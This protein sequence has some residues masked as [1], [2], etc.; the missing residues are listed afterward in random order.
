MTTKEALK[1]LLK[2]MEDLK[3]HIS[4]DEKLYQALELVTNDLLNNLLEV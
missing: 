3:K 1:I 4:Y 2:F